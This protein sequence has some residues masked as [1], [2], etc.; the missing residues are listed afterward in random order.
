M[1]SSVCVRWWVINP[2]ITILNLDAP[3]FSCFNCKE[4]CSHRNNIKDKGRST[5]IFTDSSYCVPDAFQPVTISFI[6]TP[7]LVFQRHIPWKYICLFSLWLDIQL[8][9]T[10]IICACTQP[11]ISKGSGAPWSRYISEGGGVL[12]P[13]CQ[14]SQPHNSS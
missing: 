4:F 9:L 3:D 8:S 6:L 11:Y 14:S 2:N 12:L 1:Q 10:R 13:A 5:M 7:H